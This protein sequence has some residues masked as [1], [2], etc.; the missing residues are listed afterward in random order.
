MS[1]SVLLKSIWES[2]LWL[3]HDLDP[4]TDGLTLLRMEEADYRAASFLDQRVIGPASKTE[5]LPWQSVAEALPA[6]ARRDVQCIFHIGNV[7]STLISRLLGE[8]PE[9]FALREPLLLRTFFEM[10]GS[11]WDEGEADRRIDTLRALLSRTFR[12]EQ[13]AIVKATSFTSELAARLV[14]PGSRAL[15]LFASPQHYIE[16]I[17][18]G[19]NSRTTAEMLAPA[20]LERLRSRCEGLALDLARLGPAHKAA[21]GWA[22]EMTSLEHNAARLPPGAVMWL[23]FDEFLNDAVSSFTAVAAH[24]GHP[25]S[26][27]AAAAICGGPLMRRYSKALEYEYSPQLR[28]DILAQARWRHGAGIREALGWLNALANRYPALAQAIRRAH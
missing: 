25:V 6:Q 28:R 13:R 11:G 16:N 12:P 20:R 27:A 23:D 26:P 19:E 9:V 2:P 15:F 4:A 1:Q 7:G 21:L 22:C 18:A 14:P 24:F 5:T 10:I 3:A 8:L 17:L